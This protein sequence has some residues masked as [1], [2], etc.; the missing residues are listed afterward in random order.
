MMF[1]FVLGGWIGW[2]LILTF[3]PPRAVRTRKESR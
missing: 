1:L 3:D 2:Q